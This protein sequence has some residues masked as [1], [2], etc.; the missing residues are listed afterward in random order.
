MH[1]IGEKIK[2]ARESLGMTAAELARKSDVY[3]PY[4]CLIEHGKAR[5][6]KVETLQRIC[7]ALNVSP[8]DLM[9]WEPNSLEASNG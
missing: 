8:N 7:Q 1:H 6:F 2:L 9:E 4:L 3:Q 5:G